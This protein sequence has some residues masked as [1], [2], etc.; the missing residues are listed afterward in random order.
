MKST[1]PCCQFPDSLINAISPFSKIIALDFYD[2]PTGG[3]LQCAE[4]QSVWK[5]DM[6]DWD[7]DHEIRI[8]RLARLPEDSLENCIRS[9]A[10]A[11]FSPPWPVWLPSRVS[12]EAFQEQADKKVEEILTKARPAELLLAWSG[13]G[14]KVIAARKLSP[15]KFDGVPD[16]FS[17][18]NRNH[19]HDWFSLLGLKQLPI[20]VVK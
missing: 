7:N 12:D 3:I 4:C 17:R 11:D 13:Y 1:I 10:T 16:W 19:D 18:D 14:E 20:G 9:L 5:F 15:D 8:F 2:G 6:L